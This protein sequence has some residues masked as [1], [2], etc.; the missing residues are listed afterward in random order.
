M[1]QRTLR[2][3]VSA[4]TLQTC[5]LAQWLARQVSDSQAWAQTEPLDYLVQDLLN[6]AREVKE[7]QIPVP[8]RINIACQQFVH[9]Y[10]TIQLILIRTPKSGQK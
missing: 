10:L 2:A 3:H 8:W 7:R 1:D 4:Y 5:N 9:L 6:A